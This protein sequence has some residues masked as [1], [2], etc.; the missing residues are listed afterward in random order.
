MPNTS[1]YSSQDDISFIPLTRD[2]EKQLFTRFHA[3]PA[4]NPSADSLAARDEIIARHL[5][6]VAKLSLRFAKGTLR[7]DDAISAGNFGLIQ[8]LESRCFDPERGTLFSSYVRAYIRGQILASLRDLGWK[9]EVSDDVGLEYAPEATITGHLGGEDPVNATS[10]AWDPTRTRN[11]KGAR[12][13]YPARRKGAIGA[14]VDHEG[15]ETVLKQERLK[16]IGEALKKLP[17][18]EA[19]TIH[20]HFFGDRNFADV[21]RERKLTREG[22]RKAFNRGMAKL[23]ELL[24]EREEELL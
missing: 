18:L 10:D 21:G 5:K 7:D 11:G 23:Q 16:A 24:K 17:E 8:A 14:I 22:V 3:S 6:L 2:E 19:A 9:G 20:A 15:E 4:E 12:F 13:A 1:Y